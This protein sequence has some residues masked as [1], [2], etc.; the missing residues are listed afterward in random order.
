MNREERDAWASEIAAFRYCLIA[1]LT[2]Q[3]R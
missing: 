3:A 1:E 2:G